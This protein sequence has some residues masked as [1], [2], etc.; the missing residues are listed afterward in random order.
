VIEKA[1]RYVNSLSNSDLTANQTKQ[2]TVL[3]RE[4]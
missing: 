3:Q 1:T 2:K 4:K